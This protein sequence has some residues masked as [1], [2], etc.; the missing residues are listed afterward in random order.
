MIR[1]AKPAVHFLSG[2]ACILASAQLHAA[3][4]HFVASYGV[5]GNGCT[6]AAPCRTINAAVST[7]DVGGEVLILD[8]AGYGPFFVDRSVSIIAPAGVYAGVSVGSLQYG[9][10]IGG[11]DA[12]VRLV[13]LTINGVSPN[14][15]GGVNTSGAASLDIERTAIRGTLS[16][17]SINGSYT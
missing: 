8:S 1:I 11:L 10:Q 6:L 13:G 5:D 15:T 7:V 14:A 17:I 9:A 16:G 3:Q 4:R 2:I 12:R